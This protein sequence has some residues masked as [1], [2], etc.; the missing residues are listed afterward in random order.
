MRELKTKSRPKIEK[1]VAEL[2]EI[3][4]EI[5]KEDCSCL[6]VKLKSLSFP[7][8]IF[9]RKRQVKRKC[10]FSVANLR[11]YISCCES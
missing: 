3:N 8:I 10:Q 9:Q 4:F 2:V 1:N 11:K 7:G 6:R 5:Y